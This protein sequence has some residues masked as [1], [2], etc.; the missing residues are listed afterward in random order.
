MVEQ[1]STLQLRLHNS[2]TL[3]Y[4]HISRHFKFIM[5]CPLRTRASTLTSS[6]T[7]PFQGGLESLQ[8]SAQNRCLVCYLL[9][10]MVETQ[11]IDIDL[12]PKHELSKLCLPS[13]VSGHAQGYYRIRARCDFSCLYI[14]CCAREGYA[15]LLDFDIKADTYKYND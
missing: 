4:L 1:S 15:S 14:N 9:R 12:G 7:G 5:L 8:L 13:N 10:N 11:R 6:G 3:E 2:S